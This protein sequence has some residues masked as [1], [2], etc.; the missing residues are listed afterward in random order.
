MAFLWSLIKKNFIF[1][2]H[3]FPLLGEGLNKNPKFDRNFLCL[4]DKK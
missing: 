4:L 1:E 3:T 2:S